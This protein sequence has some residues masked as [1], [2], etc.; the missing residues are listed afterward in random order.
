M[1][2]WQI[3]IKS[4]REQSRDILTLSLTIVLAPVF[5]FVYSLFFS[6][7]GSTTYQVA[8]IDND[9][10]YQE[11]GTAFNAGIQT[12]TALQEVTYS[13]GQPFLDVQLIQDLDLALQALT[14]REIE[15][16]VV[17][18]EDFSQSLAAYQAGRVGDVQAKI[19]F[20]GDLTNPYYAVAAVFANMGIETYVQG[21]TGE[22]RPF[23]IEEIPLGDSSGRSEFEIYVPGMLVFAIVLLVFQVAMTV[24]YEVESGTLNRLKISGVR[25]AELLGGISLSV[26]VI[27]AVSLSL[28]FLA[29]VALGFTSYGSIWL[30]YLVGL[31][32]TF[33]VI[34][35]G[36]LVAAFSNSVSQAFII[37]NFPLMIFMFFTGVA[38]PIPDVPLFTMGNQAVGLYDFLPPTHAVTAFNKILTLGGGL[39][40]ISYELLA[41]VVLTVLYFGVGIFVFRKRHMTVG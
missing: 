20:Y 19:V 36:L 27:G 12:I 34:G 35:A 1:K 13:D 2:L 31:L 39:G 41:L 24:A 40:D 38:F 14:D 26:V 7:G 37:A 4:L 22:V 32:T 21:V 8:V 3:F 28:A 15:V 25:S 6:S 29:A 10:P 11:A 18:P 23:V 17:L 16:V 9:T 33:S 5:V 30:A